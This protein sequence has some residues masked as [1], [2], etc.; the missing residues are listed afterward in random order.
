MSQP[1]LVAA[2]SNVHMGLSHEGLSSVAEKFGIKIDKLSE[3][4]LI[5]YI[6]RARDKLKVLGAKGIVLGYVKMRKGATLPLGAVQFIPETFSGRGTIDIDGAIQKYLAKTL[7]RAK[8]NRS[9]LDIVR[10][11]KQ[12]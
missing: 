3:S 6:N 7:V 11:M 2:I 1:R 12:Q 10:A 5:L 9:A 8:Q 4:D